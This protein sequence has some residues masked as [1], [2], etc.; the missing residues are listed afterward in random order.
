M[1]SGMGRS[2][3]CRKQFCPQPV[4]CGEYVIYGTLRP[5]NP[6][7]QRLNPAALRWRCT[8]F[9]LSGALADFVLMQLLVFWSALPD[10]AGAL[11]T[12]DRLRVACLD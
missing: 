4:S 6:V 2:L 12:R 1:A 8:V 9:L 3:N 11:I 7:L 10:G 5:V